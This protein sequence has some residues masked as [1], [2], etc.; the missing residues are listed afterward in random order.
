MVP[1]TSLE[2]GENMIGRISARFRRVA[3][4]R[5]RIVVEAAR[6]G[7]KSWR[8]SEASRHREVLHDQWD[9]NR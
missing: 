8:A 6:T 7:R 5:G 1:G 4:S 9:G 2:L 3:G